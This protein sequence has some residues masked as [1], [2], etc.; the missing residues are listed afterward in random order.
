MISCILLGKSSPFSRC[1][2]QLQL[3]CLR[4][5]L[6]TIPSNKS[7]L[8]FSGSISLSLFQASLQEPD[9][10]N[11]RFRVEIH[12]LP[13]G[14]RSLNAISK[15]R[16]GR[17]WGV[18][19]LW[20]RMAAHQATS[21]QSKDLVMFNFKADLRLLALSRGSPGNAD[22]H[23]KAATSISDSFSLWVERKSSM[24]KWQLG[25]IR[26]SADG[27][28][29]RQSTGPLQAREVGLPATYGTPM[30]YTWVSDQQWLDR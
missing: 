11:P 12:H 7:K 29:V 21:T 2:E 22:V 28:G 18:V 27:L 3:T 26:P 23:F 13:A 30:T 8:D 25:Y 15:G 10:P 9:T 17:G 5:L 6:N 20:V 19:C 24:L 14:R 1:W 4:R 16:G